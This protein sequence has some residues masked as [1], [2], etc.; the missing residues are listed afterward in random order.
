[1]IFPETSSLWISHIPAERSSVFPSHSVPGFC[2]R[3]ICPER[4]PETTLYGVLNG[5]ARFA[6]FPPF[7]VDTG[8]FTHYNE[9]EIKKEQAPIN[10][11]DE[12]F[13]YFADFLVIRLRFIYLMNHAIT[14]I[15]IKYVDLFKFIKNH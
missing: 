3:K 14:S 9:P 10:K 4:S 13:N 7:S 6:V 15:L 1:M 8:C 2:P 11:N 5:S 12:L